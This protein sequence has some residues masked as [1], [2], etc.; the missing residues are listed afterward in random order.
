MQTLTYAGCV[1]AAR[2]FFKLKRLTAQ[3]SRLQKSGGCVYQAGKY[4]CAIGASFTD[5]TMKE[6]KRRKFNK[7]NDLSRIGPATTT[8]AEMVKAGIVGIKKGEL[9]KITKLQQTHDNW[10][11]GFAERVAKSHFCKLIGVKPD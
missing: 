3:S 4:R 8:I 1:K 6:I 7:P 11:L 5:A 9:R 10:A 2:K